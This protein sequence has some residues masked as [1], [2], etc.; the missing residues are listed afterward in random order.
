MLGIKEI[1]QIIPHR[2][3]FLLID[4][5]ESVEAGVRAVGYKVLRFMKI[6]LQDIFRKSLLCLEY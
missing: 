2:H 6:F 5:I 1:E 4:C 3:P